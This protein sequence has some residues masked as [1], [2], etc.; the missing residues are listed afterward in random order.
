MQ[1]HSLTI[2]KMEWLK[3]GSSPSQTR[4]RLYNLDKL[5]IR[6]CSLVSCFPRSVQSDF[7]QNEWKII[8][9]PLRRRER[10]SNRVLSVLKVFILSCFLRKGG[11]E[12]FSKPLSEPRFRRMRASSP[13]PRT[14][15]CFPLWFTFFFYPPS[16]IITPF[17]RGANRISL[18]LETRQGVKARVAGVHHWSMR[19]MEWGPSSKRAG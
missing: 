5:E 14:P 4:D 12:K 7:K 11:R 9:P 13:K 2:M 17:S 1:Q 10:A 19:K 15:R 8:H 6:S 18:S 3:V 16:Y